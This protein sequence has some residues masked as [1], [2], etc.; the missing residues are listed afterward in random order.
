MAPKKGPLDN[1]K[2]IKLPKGKKLKN[3]YTPFFILF[4]LS[5]ALAAMLP[6]LGSSV[7]TINEKI[8]VSALTEN[9]NAG[10]YS[11]I[12]IDGNKA[13]A[14]LSG[15]LSEENGITKQ[16]IQTAILPEKDSLAD[17]GLKN[18]E[19]LTQVEVKD[20]SSEKFWAGLFPTIVMVILFLAIGIFLISRM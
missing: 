16:Q 2:N 17:L 11:K 20:L 12:L 14:T 1:L 5:L 3:N 4:A 19:I 13:I 6:Y 10:K 7:T 9:Y 15:G 18:E 8:A